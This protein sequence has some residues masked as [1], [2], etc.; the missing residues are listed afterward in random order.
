MYYM[1]REGHRTKKTTSQDKFLKFVYTH[2][3][4]RVLMR[5]L[6]L[7]AVSRLGGKLLNT[8][9]S[10]VFAGLFARTHGIDLNKY[11]KQKFDSYND[12]FTRKLKP[13]ARL[14]AQGD[15][16]LI[17]PC[18]GK[19]SVY[20]IHENGRFFIKHTPYTTH[21]LIRDAKLARHYMG[22]WAVVIR[23]T[24]DDYHRYCY[25]ADGEKTYQRRIPGIFHTVNPIANDICP[26]YK[27]NSREYCLVKNEKL[28]TVLM[29]EVGALMVGKIRNYKKERC[30]VK[31]GEEKGRFEFGGSTIIVM[32]EPGKVIP[33]QDLRTNTREHAET[34]VKMGEHIGAQ[35]EQ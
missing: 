14:L 29:M 21:S 30:Q 35:I 5:P 32:T 22:G 23:L 24:V 31:R 10:A 17:S 2:T 12:F 20:P 18:D 26:I 34:L 7:P 25:V 4:T 16:I 1:D 28:G 19:A 3:A 11:E 8:K 6:L 13:D 33:D 9:V 27:M 15:D